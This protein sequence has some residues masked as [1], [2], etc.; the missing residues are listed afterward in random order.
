MGCMSLLC[1]DICEIHT[2]FNLLSLQHNVI[3]KYSSCVDNIF[4]FYNSKYLRANKSSSNTSSKK[5]TNLNNPPSLQRRFHILF[6]LFLIQMY[7]LLKIKIKSKLLLIF[8]T[9]HLILPPCL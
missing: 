4:F 7:T 2:D 8:N 3:S 1:W 9:A 5:G 6:Y